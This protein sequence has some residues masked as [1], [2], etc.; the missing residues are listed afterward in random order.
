ME[1]ILSKYKFQVELI[2]NI[3]YHQKTYP[4]YQISE[5]NKINPKAQILL[6][7]A[8]HGLEKIGANIIFSFLKII[9]NKKIN[10]ENIHIIAIPIANPYGYVN[11]TRCNGNNVDLMRNAPFDAERVVPFLGGHKISNFFPYYRGEKLEEEN[12]ILV[13]L[14]DE[15]LL[16]EIPLFHLDIHSGFGN[17]TEIWTPQ[18]TYIDVNNSLYRLFKHSCFIFKNQPY[19]SHGDMLKYLFDTFKHKKKYV[20]VTLEIGFFYKINSL[21][22]ISFWKKFLKNPFKFLKFKRWFFSPKYGEK[23]KVIRVH[24]QFLIDLVQKINKNPLLYE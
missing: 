1:K 10:L 21:K 23:R 6:T 4:V 12:L 18:D 14:V 13:N 5:G 22:E 7:G 2:K 17:E 20:P 19:N 24:T 3:E 8:I 11:E 9:K 16:K 15:L